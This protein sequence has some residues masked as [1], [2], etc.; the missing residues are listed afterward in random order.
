MGSD[1]EKIFSQMEGGGR[2][3][4]AVSESPHG[5]SLSGEAGVS[6]RRHS[7]MRGWEE[8]WAEADSSSPHNARHPLQP[9]VPAHLLLH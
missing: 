3:R 7:G 6:T 5:R 2:I 9:M 8:E 4:R 1:R